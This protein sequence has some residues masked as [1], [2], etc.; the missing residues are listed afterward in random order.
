MVHQFGYAPEDVTGKSFLDFIHTDDV[1][2]ISRRFAEIRKGAINPFEFRLAD[3]TGKFRQVRSSSRP[4][5]S[6]DLFSGIR[7][8]L[9]DITDQKTAEEK[10]IAGEKRYRNVFELASDAMLVLDNDTGT[11]FDANGA[12]VR[13]FGHS[14]E[15]MRMLHHSDLYAGPEATG[16]AEEI[17]NCL[18]SRCF[19]R[20]KDGGVFPAEISV[21][22]Y[23]QK[24]HTISILS[25]RDITE[26]KR[27]EERTTAINRIYALLSEINEVIVRIKNLEALLNESAGSLSNREISGWPGSACWTR[28]PLPFIRWPMRDLKTG[29]SPMWN[30]PSVTGMHQTTQR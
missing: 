9:T 5:F 22:T 11:I 30:S 2:E 21:S 3:K 14:P 1:P 15:E 16:T 12:A 19:Y 4:V 18:L 20:K 29:F 6:G 24:K 17:E 23:P 7:G 13:L 10:I 27:S 8:I 26:R 28:K 25:V